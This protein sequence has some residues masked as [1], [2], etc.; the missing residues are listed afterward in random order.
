MRRRCG[1]GMVSARAS[2]G[3]GSWRICPR[4]GASCD[5]PSPLLRVVGGKDLSGL[6]GDGNVRGVGSGGSHGIAPGL[7]SDWVLAVVEMARKE[8]FWEFSGNNG[9][10]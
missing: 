6:K 4:G 5:D 9:K 2:S 7:G 1:S 8:K 3:V 10:R